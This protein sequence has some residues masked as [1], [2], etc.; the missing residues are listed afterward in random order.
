MSEAEQLVSRAP[1]LAYTHYLLG[2]AYLRNGKLKQAEEAAKE[3]LGLDPT[4]APSYGL[5]AHLE[6]RRSR[7]A[8]AKNWAE[9]GLSFD[10]ENTDCANA[11]A[12]ALQQ[13]GEFEQA[14][15]TVDQTLQRDPENSHAHASKG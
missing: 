5:H 3:A 15:A 10:P 13:M 6:L 14:H 8:G 1:E 9:H 12:L 11:R 4:S 2:L 7:W